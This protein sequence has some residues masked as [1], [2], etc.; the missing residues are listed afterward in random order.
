MMGFFQTDNSNWKLQNEKEPRQ[1]GECRAFSQSEVG[2]MDEEVSGKESI[3][4]ISSGGGST[5]TFYFSIKVQI[6]WRKM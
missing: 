2:R 5:L 6:D 3:C 4:K 1:A